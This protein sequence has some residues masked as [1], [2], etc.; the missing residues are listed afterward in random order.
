MGDFLS[1]KGVQSTDFVEACRRAQSTSPKHGHF[2]DI[3]VSSTSYSSFVDLMRVMRPAAE[4]VAQQ[5]AALGRGG[6]EGKHAERRELDQ[7]QR[8]LAELT[9]GRGRRD[10][11]EKSASA[12]DRGK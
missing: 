2:L 6:S 12:A 4:F 7:E 5:Q 8:D 11:E 10:G 9:G 3:V 1:M